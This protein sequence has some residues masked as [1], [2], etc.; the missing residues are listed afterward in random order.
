MKD[1][2]LI[3]IDMDGTLLNNN[4]E[5]TSENKTAILKA[6]SKGVNIALC[7][8][9]IFLSARYYSDLL[10]IDTAVIASNGAFI[11]KGYDDEPIFENTMPKDL[12][13]EIY[14]IVKKH[15]LKINFNSWDTLIR[16]EE[17]PEEHTYF[18]MN[19]TLP[20]ER[21]VKFI[22]EKDLVS[23]INKF[24]GN[25]LKGIVS[26]KDNL[27][28]LFECKEELK[29][30]FG[31]RLHVVSSG[32]DNFEVMAGST[33]KG[34]AVKHLAEIL[35]IDREDIMCIGD[36]ENDLS[37]LEFAGVSVAMG[38][39]MNLVKEAATFITDTNENSGVAK[40]I[41]K[42]IFHI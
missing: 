42:F 15:G 11:K 5:V 12:A 16:E 28:A 14:N 31:E 6:Y 33:S 1:I 36:S 29:S 3:C 2:K 27:K 4:H 18:V 40:A 35:N 20:K 21:Q 37:M 10:G 41:E 22:V 34:N 25:I 19:R 9:R 17:V 32:H 39:G 30:T 38:N 7:T 26:D 24:E 13:L 8:G 23:L